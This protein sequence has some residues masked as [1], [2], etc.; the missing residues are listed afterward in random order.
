VDGDGE[1]DNG[2]DT[3]SDGINDENDDDDDGDG[4]TDEEE[5]AAG[6]N[7][8]DEEDHP[9]EGGSDEPDFCS[10]TSEGDKLDLFQ[11]CDDDSYLAKI[12]ANED[13]EDT[14]FIYLTLKDDSDTIMVYQ[15]EIVSGGLGEGKSYVSSVSYG[16][17]S[18]ITDME[19]VVLDDWEDPT[20]TLE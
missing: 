17:D 10:H 9:K 15:K 6:T 1:I 19:V 2:V 18:V 8:L 20:I 12:N 11:S 7:P 4:Y 16:G 14:F 5:L 3:D 13:I